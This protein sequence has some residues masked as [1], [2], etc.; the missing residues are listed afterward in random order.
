MDLNTSRIIAGAIA[1]PLGSALLASSLAIGSGA[2]T[3]SFLYSF[4]VIFA[5]F[6][7]FGAVCHFILR[8]KKWHKLKQYLSVMFFVAS[9]SIFSFYVFSLVWIFGNGGSEFHFGTQVVEN[10]QLTVGGLVVTL[11]EAMF[12]AGWLCLSFALFWFIAVR[13]S[14]ED[15]NMPNHS[16]KSDAAKPRTLG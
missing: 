6:L 7:M 13:S 9:V 4:V 14:S 8:W 2:W 5:L 3:V 12:G 10:G 11:I 16:L 15:R 1:G